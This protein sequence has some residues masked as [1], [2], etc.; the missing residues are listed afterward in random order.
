MLII[1]CYCKCVSC[2]YTRRAVPRSSLLQERSAL[3]AQH[4]NKINAEMNRYQAMLQEKD[5]LSKKWDEEARTLCLLAIFHIAYYT[6][7]LCP[8][9]APLNP[10]HNAKSSPIALLCGYTGISCAKRAVLWYC[11]E[12]KC[13]IRDRQYKMC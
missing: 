1:C 13:C 3:E 2:S 12:N 7:Q 8:C 11:S 9:T 10:L 4:K 5:D 6:A